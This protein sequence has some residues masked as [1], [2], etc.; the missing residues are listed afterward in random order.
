MNKAGEM[1]YK[2]LLRFNKFYNKNL[3]GEY[4][5]NLNLVI[6]SSMLF[7]YSE[8]LISELCR[9]G[10]EDSLSISYFSFFEIEIKLLQQYSNLE[11]IKKAAK[12]LSDIKAA[13]M[14]Y[15]MVY[16]KSVMDLIRTENLDAPVCIVSCNIT[17]AVDIS[18]FAVKSSAY[19]FFDG[20]EPVIEREEDVG[21]LQK[22]FGIRNTG[23]Q[24][25]SQVTKLKARVLWNNKVP[26]GQVFINGEHY[27]LKNDCFEIE[28]GG[29]AEL[30]KMRA[31]N[32]I[33]KLFVRMSRN[34][35]EKLQILLEAK[36]RGE[37]VSAFCI[38]PEAL[39]ITAD[40]A[41]A[42]YVMEYVTGKRLDRYLFELSQDKTATIEDVVE[43]FLQI[44]LAV[45]TV[46]LNDFIIGDLCAYNFIVA[47]GR[48]RIVDCD[49]FQIK[50]Y[51][52]DGFHME[53]NHLKG[54]FLTCYDDFC[55][56]KFMYKSLIELFEKRIVD[57]YEEILKTYHEKINDISG[58]IYAFYYFLHSRRRK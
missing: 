13:A 48:I 16:H 58:F 18:R 53:A 17:E 29:E 50:N 41:Y 30:Y 25:D 5:K 24:F 15:K 52:C 47:E 44:A 10:A 49:S 6:A 8:Y 9:N 19:L 55:L 12:R 22:M 7:A 28:P 4:R 27:D 26:N 20:Y 14:P 1:A 51:P 11:I 3:K 23:E 45:H 33:L 32:R 46:H 36:E 54:K 37:I 2:E 43:I 57:E 56:L 34:K 38:L 42:G 31:D 40:E 35:V 21:I 39:V